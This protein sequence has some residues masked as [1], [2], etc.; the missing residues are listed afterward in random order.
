MIRRTIARD[1]MSV[2]PAFAGRTSGTGI[3]HA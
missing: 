3:M 2:N 1:L